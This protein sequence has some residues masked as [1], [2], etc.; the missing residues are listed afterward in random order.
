MMTRNGISRALIAVALLWTVMSLSYPFGWDQGI[1]SWAGDIVV[2]GGIPYRDAWDM[3]GPLVYYVFAFTEMIFGVHLWG[4]RVVDAAFLVAATACI[5]RAVSKLTDPTA[6]HWSAI[7][8]FLWYAS[9]SYWHTAQPD[10]WVG[11]LMAVVMLPPLVQAEPIGLRRMG[12]IGSFIGLMSLVKP[13]FTVFLVL[14][15][16]YAFSTR[17]SRRVLCGAA[18][19]AGWLLPIVVCAAW[20]KG[21]GALDDLLAVYVRYPAATYAEL[22][23]VGLEER[24]RGIVE[25]LFRAPIVAVGLPIVII[26]AL[27]L[28]QTRRAVALV[29]VAW[30]LLAA[31]LVVLQ[32]RF[33][34]YHWIPLLPA[35]VV[36]GA[37]G[38]HAVLPRAKALVLTTLTIAVAQ[39]LAPIGLEELRYLSWVTG[40]TDTAAYYDGYGEAGNDMRSVDWL[41]EKGAEGKIFVFG[42]NTSIA[43]LSHRAT[44]S[45]FGFSM[46]L[47]IGQDLAIR[48][49]YRDELIRTLRSDPPRYIILGTQSQRILR[50]SLAIADFPALADLVHNSYARAA[51]FGPIQI[52]ERGAMRPEPQ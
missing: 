50:T 41:R 49:E 27:A 38:C 30:A 47:L 51:E 6:G 7:L 46:P 8:F 13:I 33:F 16:L 14:P 26:G 9:H 40:R 24:A 12:L 21:H 10:G 37:V 32:G 34:A 29:L 5:G 22:G 31:F 36:L 43:W 17:A 42:W 45:R 19:V 4:I 18:L 35:T 28:W 25:Y 2:R 20:F 15:L 44:V 3:K 11:M 23:T 48:A 39:C 52:Y 1:L